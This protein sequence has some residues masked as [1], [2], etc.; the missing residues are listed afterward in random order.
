V[1]PLTTPRRLA[2]RFVLAL[3]AFGL[4]S[5][6]LPMPSLAVGVTI[7]IEESFDPSEVT[8]APGTTITWVNDSG[9]RRRVRTT[10][11][12]AEFDSGNLEAGQKF[13]VTLT[14]PGTYNYLDDRNKDDSAYWAR[15]VVSA[16][17]PAPTAPGDASG[18]AQP[19]P[20]P[21]AASVGMA[22][23][24][25]RPS[26]VTIAPGGS[27]TWRN[28]DDRAHTVSATTDAFDSGTLSPGQA[29]T[30]TFPTAG[31][32]AYLCLIHPNMTGTV[33]VVA[34]GTTAPPPA[35]TPVPTPA[36]AAP[37]APAAPGTIRAVDFAFQPTSLTVAAGSRVS[38]VN[39][40]RAPHTMTARDGTFDSGI[41]NA[42]GTWAHSFATPGTY[43]FL[44]SLHPQMVGT[45]RVTDG[46]GKAPPPAPTPVPTPAPAAPAAPAGT[47]SFAIRDFTFQP[48]TIRVPVGSTVRW[49]NQGLA[50]HTVTD[51]AGS[52]DSGFIEAGGSW[53]NTF[54][55]PGTFA[56]WCVIHPDMTGR[57]EVTT[58]GAGG[59]A[60]PALPSPSAAPPASATPGASPAP[61]A[62]VSNPGPEGSATIG[63]GS[64]DTAQVPSAPGPAG[65]A[66]LVVIALSIVLVGGAATLFMRAINGAIGRAE[67][68]PVV[69]RPGPTAH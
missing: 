9:D 58:S 56:I 52:F 25:F 62:A 63:D 2:A 64:G 66:S 13:S 14:A 26:N 22:G 33:V 27:V 29:Y 49:V 46:S 39:A 20:A 55:Q 7:R 60:A 32:Y 8:V 50:P 38:F 69:A 65:V 28:D 5:A 1:L 53:S 6:A 41:I 11:G 30:R 57:I 68:D 51:R 12:P 42:A 48:S 17:A 59:E 61:I 19:P 35:P 10:S 67:V 43:A 21:S 47:S 3:A 34:E 16:Q 23:E 15:I 54:G 24:V 40:G 44:C 31:S 45:L 18:G 37:A 4:V 36:P